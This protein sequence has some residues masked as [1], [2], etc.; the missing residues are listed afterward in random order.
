MNRE[1]FLAELALND[2][3]NKAGIAGGKDLSA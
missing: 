3:H 2:H 1:Q